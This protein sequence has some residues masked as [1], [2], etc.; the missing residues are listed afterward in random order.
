[1]NTKLSSFIAKPSRLSVDLMETTSLVTDADYY[2]SLDGNDANPGSFDSPF[3]TINQAK[4]AVRKRI[5]QGLPEGGL[6]IAIKQGIYHTPCI[7]F[8]SEDSGSEQAPIKYVAYG[9]GQVILNG[10]V[11]LNCSDFKP[12]EGEQKARLSKEAGKKVVCI[13]LGDYGIS[14]EDYGKLYAIGAFHTAQKY[15][16]DTTGAYHCEV[17]FNHERMTMARY[18]NGKD[19]LRIEKV[20]D[21]GDCYEPSP[22]DYQPDWLEKRNPRGGTFKV[23]ATT[24]E[25]LKK[26]KNT[27]DIWAFG[28]FYW[29]WADMSTPVESI[30]LSEGTITTSYCSRYGFKEQALYHFYNVFE[31]LDEPG[32]YYLDRETGMLYLFPVGDIQDAT[33]QITLTTKSIIQIEKGAKHLIF[34]GLSIEG[35]RG[36]GITL[37]GDHCTIHKCRINNIAQSGILV[38]GTYNKIIGNEISKVGQNGIILEGGDQLTL[39]PG[40][41]L[42]DNNHIHHYGE[43]QRTYTAGV[44]LSGVANTASH[45]EIHD[46]P[47]MAIRYSG[48]D[49][50]IEYNEIYNVVL[51]SSDAGAIYSGFEVCDQGNVLRYNCI[52]NIGSSEFKPQGIYFDD[53]MAGQTAYGNILVNIPHCGFLIGGGRDNKVYRNLIINAGVPIS[54]DGRLYEGFHSQGWFKPHV[55]TKDGRYW[56]KVKKAKEMNAKWGNKYPNI[57]EIHDDFDHPEDKGFAVNPTGSEV[58]DNIIGT[59]FG[60]IG[61]I[62]PSSAAYAK[63]ENNKVYE[64]QEIDIAQCN[65]L[66]IPI[67]QIGRRMTT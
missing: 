17:F 5:Q 47:H 33:I 20:L 29:D 52:Y 63:I 54:F 58:T 53:G 8:E 26:W 48:N 64:L 55:L 42:A 65:L 4:Q 46:A 12:V 59:N 36:D 43:I 35:T 10:G 25:R 27:Q 7:T 16:G 39:T 6:T 61:Y 2:V 32:E 67:E 24:H 45:N 18:P 60:S 40:Y 19:N 49:H 57:S 62:A 3:A 23:D 28:Y 30:D 44:K 51:H 56:E 66:Q 15:D 37:S 22:Q 1:M 41:N 9:D 11:N 21:I 31:E 50:Y 38:N 34:E 13:N 14:K